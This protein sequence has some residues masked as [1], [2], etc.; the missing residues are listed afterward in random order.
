MG[1]LP[2]IAVDCVNLSMRGGKDVFFQ[3]LAGL[4]QRKSRGRGVRIGPSKMNRWFR[5][6]LPKMHGEQ[7]FKDASQNYG[8]FFF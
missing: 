4:L 2:K 3:G 8:K 6:G 5:I 1:N 7:S